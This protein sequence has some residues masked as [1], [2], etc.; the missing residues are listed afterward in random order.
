MIFGTPVM[1][2]FSVYF[3]F[4]GCAKPTDVAQKVSIGKL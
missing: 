3:L 2:V 4:M 1:E